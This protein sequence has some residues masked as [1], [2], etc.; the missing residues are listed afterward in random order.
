MS[1]QSCGGGESSTCWPGRPSCCASISPP[2]RTSASRPSSL[3]CAPSAV[4]GW[5]AGGRAAPGDP[6]RG[7]AAPRPRRAG[8]L[9]AVRASRRRGR[10]L[11][12]GPRA[13]R[14]ASRAVLPAVPRVLPQPGDRRVITG[15]IMSGG[16]EGAGG[17]RQMG[18][19]E[20]IVIVTTM[21]WAAAPG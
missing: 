5:W 7:S 6:Q 14:R 19:G 17:P 11:R 10:A 8:T 16:G 12:A 1:I 13:A 2:W 4:R 3:S 15:I 21:Q 18:A 9:A 20:A